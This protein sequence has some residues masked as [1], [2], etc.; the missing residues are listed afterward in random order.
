MQWPSCG[1][2]RA[3]LNSFGYGGTNAHVII[4]AY[5]ER[6]TSSTPNLFHPN[7]TAAS[8]TH[9]THEEAG[10][11][12]RE[13]QSKHLKQ[14]FLLT[15]RNKTGAERL[16]GSLLAYLKDRGEM[17]PHDL[18][19]LAFTTGV[20]RTKFDW[21]IA[22]MASSANELAGALESHNFEAKKVLPRPQLA[23][24]FT[25]QGAQWYAMGRELIEHYSVFKKA[26]LLADAYLQSIGASWSV[27]DELLKDSVDSR[28]NSAAIGQPLCTAVQCALVDLFYSWGIRP[29]SVIG[30]SS[31]EIA[32]AY[33][34]GSL[35]LHSALAVSYHRG[36]LASAKLEQDPKLQGGMLAAGLSE[37]EAERLISQAPSDKGKAVVACINSPRSVTISGDSSAILWMQSVLNALQIFVRKLGVNTAYHSHHME[38]VAPSYLA[39]LQDLS[40]PKYNKDVD[41]FSSVTGDIL[42]GEALDANYWVSNMTSPVKFS[43]AL[44][45]LYRAPH[46]DRTMSVSGLASQ[47]TQLLLEIGAHAALAGPVKQTLATIQGSKF[48][49][50]ATLIRGK[51]AIDSTLAAAADLTVAGLPLNLE[52]V[53]LQDRDLNPQVLSNLPPYPWDHSSG[54]WHES[55]LSLNYR[56]RL[57]PR[58]PLLGAPTP[59]C[60]SIE[61]SWRNI[62]KLVEIPWLLGHKIQ[63]SVVYPAAGYITMAIEAA[64]Q[65]SQLTRP[66][67]AIAEFHLKQ[68]SV[69]KPLLIPD[70]AEGIETQFVFR[71]YNSSALSS[72]DVWDE[73]RVFSYSTHDG[74]SEHCRGL[75]AA[76]Y[77]RDKSDV[78]NDRETQFKL[79]N[80]AMV[81]SEARRLCQ[82]ITDTD[83]LYECLDANGSHF[84]NA[85]KCIEDAMVSGEQSYGHLRVPDTAETM[86]AGIE[87]PHVLHPTILDACMQMT[88]PILFHN[89]T[90]G[91][92]MVPTFVEE[93]VVSNEVPRNAGERLAVH[94]DL[95]LSTKKA[96]KAR[97][98]AYQE[99]AGDPKVPFIQILGLHCTA[100]PVGPS[101]EDQPNGDLG[102]YHRFQWDPL[103]SASCDKAG[104][105]D[106]ISTA[107]AYPTN[108]A[109]VTLLQPT[110]V[111][112]ATQSLAS[113]LCSMLSQRH[114]QTDFT[115]LENALQ[116]DGEGSVLICLTEF[117]GS[118]LN[119]LTDGQWNALRN[120]LSSPSRVLWVTQGGAMTITAPESGLINGLARSAMSD[121]PALHLVTLDVDPQPSSP[122]DTARTIISVLDKAFDSNESEETIKDKE[123]VQRGGQLYVPRVVEDDSLKQY[124]TADTRE[125][126]CQQQPFIQPRRPL[127]L[128][129]KTPGL[130]DS[131]RFIEDSPAKPILGANELKMQPRCFGVNFRDV[132]IALGR[133]EETSIMSSEH[134]GVITEVGSSLTD[135]FKVGDRICA[136]GGTPYASSVTVD[137]MSAHCIPDEMSFEE[138]A[139][140]PIV[141]ATVFYS[142]IHLARLQKGESVLIHSAAGGVGQA[143]IMMA[144]YLQAEVFVTV[145]NNEKKALVMSK[146]GIPEDHIFSSRHLTFGAGISRLTGGKGVD[147][148][149]NSIAGDAFHET[150]RC[151]AKLGRFIEI[152]KRDILEDT[153][154]AMGTFNKSVTFASVDLTIVFQHDPQLAKRMI[155]EVFALLQK[156]V[157][158][159]VQPLNVSPLNDIETAF[160]LIQAGKHTGK[161]VLKAD[162]RTNVKVSRA[163][164]FLDCS[165]G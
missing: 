68:V 118:M 44:Q 84:Q 6:V 97:I 42:S 79:A 91:S 116:A 9:G 113:S 102:K 148:V 53:N 17:T 45:Q 128:E 51:D 56:K 82:T 127:R 63:S 86:P 70:T 122:E 105:P 30:H 8:S 48:Q 18:H 11:S 155:G 104:N 34:C 140:I 137:G 99:T 89:G 110:E 146:Y 77:R 114:V 121:N 2:R 73:F 142:L 64:L 160:R 39:A 123:Y 150:F 163:S 5:Q 162:E 135:N 61:P 153:R 158:Q 57:S 29:S 31:G 107:E 141:Y 138:A 43:Q 101:Y 149:L 38:I 25:G 62:I 52:A 154:L 152:G 19:R 23:F 133:L 75:I 54:Y 95:Q 24:I 27:M 156:G 125:A 37:A 4:D 74:W 83:K 131:L 59:D 124:L 106:D 78:E 32:A 41:F 117:R 93:I 40:S 35:T 33:A 58:H 161:V 16:A 7:Q 80:Y 100:L 85:F 132:M 112:L 134:S 76:Q 129:V 159:P 12:P 71:P 55:R 164:T 157:L 20:R 109:R 47:E 126:E 165:N 15:H 136:W 130:L 21:R 94:S 139:S 3:S 1:L 72:S 60:N 103:E 90:L 144:K 108:I 119:K 14:L 111:P 26:L 96:L 92:P 151:I 143:A 28:V 66:T 115:T 87:H 81:T 98:T 36:R 10:P 120:I 88:A 145:G 147:V 46:N 67:E 69:D 22:V 50:V 13:N 65:R 49:H